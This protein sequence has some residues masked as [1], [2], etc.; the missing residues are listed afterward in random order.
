V[1]LGPLS[2]PLIYQTLAE[3]SSI[4]FYIVDGW[5]PMDIGE[6][7]DPGAAKN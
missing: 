1:S 7:W 3:S 5:I 4:R 6:L 2:G